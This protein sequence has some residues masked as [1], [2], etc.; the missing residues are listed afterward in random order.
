MASLIY[1]TFNGN[2]LRLAHLNKQRSDYCKIKKHKKQKLVKK[3][4]RSHCKKN[5]D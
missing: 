3:Q 4:P 1:C 2:V 5:H